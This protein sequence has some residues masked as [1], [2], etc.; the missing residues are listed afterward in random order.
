VLLNLLRLALLRP[1]ALSSQAKGL[2][3]YC[4]QE[5]IEDWFEFL[6]ASIAAR[7]EYRQ[8]SKRRQKKAAS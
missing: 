1:E 7:K 6:L 3:G 2:A 5:G 4:Q 8:A